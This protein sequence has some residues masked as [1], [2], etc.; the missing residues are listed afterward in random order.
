MILYAQSIHSYDFEQSLLLLLFS[1]F[2]F[3]QSRNLH[4]VEAIMATL[5]KLN[6]KPFPRCIR[7]SSMIEN[8]KKNIDWTTNNI[9]RTRQFVLAPSVVSK[10]KYTN[11]GSPLSTSLCVINHVKNM[12]SIPHIGAN[13]ISL[14]RTGIRPRMPTSMKDA[15]ILALCWINA[16][17]FRSPV[18]PSGPF[19]ACG[20]KACCYEGKGVKNV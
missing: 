16:T 3:F 6:T 2:F 15:I 5:K 18:E 7:T 17:G 20:H 12:Y 8:M 14:R 19:I 4:V 10:K 11:C 13:V 1:F 9:I